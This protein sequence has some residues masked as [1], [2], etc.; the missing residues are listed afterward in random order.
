MMIACFNAWFLIT[1]MSFDFLNAMR[2]AH[3][4]VG[5]LTLL[6]SVSYIRENHPDE[7]LLVELRTC[8]RTIQQ[9]Y[10]GVITHILIIYVV[11]RML[12]SFPYLSRAST[13]LD[14]VGAVVQEPASANK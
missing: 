13:V 8:R 14:T 12:V 9:C 3:A 11:L 2:I 7:A 4:I 5:C 6:L 1:A 10:G